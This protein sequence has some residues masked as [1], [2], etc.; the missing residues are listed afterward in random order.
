MDKGLVV[1]VAGFRE[2]LLEKAGTTVMLLLWLLPTP[3]PNHHET[4]FLCREFQPRRNP[5]P[6]R[7]G[8]VADVACTTTGVAIILGILYGDG[9]TSQRRLVVTSR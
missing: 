5:R 2:K 1:V 3:L 7:A 8:V 6:L 9:E 4:E